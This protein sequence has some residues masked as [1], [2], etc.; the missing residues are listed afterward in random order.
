MNG[1]PQTRSDPEGAGDIFEYAAYFIQNYY[2]QKR[3]QEY[4]DREY[5]QHEKKAQK[6]LLMIENF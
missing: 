2:N 4:Q 3:K 1:I 5:R 6:S